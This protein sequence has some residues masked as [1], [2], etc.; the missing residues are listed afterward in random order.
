MIRPRLPLL[1]LFAPVL[2][3]LLAAPLADAARAVSTPA[4]GDD[5]PREAWSV[6]APGSAPWR[7]HTLDSAVLIEDAAGAVT[8]LDL[9]T[10]TPRW[11]VEMGGPLDVVPREHAGVTVLC[12]G[13]RCVALDVASGARLDERTLPSLAAAPGVAH[14]GQL[15]VLTLAGTLH[16][17]TLGGGQAWAYRG[18]ETLGTQL[19]LVPTRERPMLVLTEGTRE[20]VAL[21]AQA[22]LPERAAWRT[23]VNAAPLGALQLVGDTLVT[24]LQNG[25]VLALAAD[26]GRVQW[27]TSLP[28]PPGAPAL[29]AGDVVLT[30]GAWGLQAR[31]VT[32]GRVLWSRPDAALPR[33]TNTS[34]ALIQTGG[35]RSAWVRARDGRELGLPAHVPQQLRG[36]LLLAWDGTRLR[37]YHARH[38]QLARSTPGSGALN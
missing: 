34:S 32:D 1:R 3:V 5:S 11:R 24:A 29:T 36:G 9:A 37:A 14:Q 12:A 4:P 38:A 6:A 8:G 23:A 26:S 30:G 31:A 2:A 13:L 25:E 35:R 7:V 27:R 21:P 17:Y 19:R 20:I 28:G 16:V 22:R 15:Y 10:G 33:A 18:R